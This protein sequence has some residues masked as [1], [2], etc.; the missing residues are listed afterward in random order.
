[1]TETSTGY[2]HPERPSG[3]TE[4]LAAL[5]LESA[6]LESI[7][8]T[9]PQLADLALILNGAYQPLRG[10]MNQADYE[11]VLGNLRLVDGSPF[12]LPVTLDVDLTTAR[13]METGKRIT[14]RDG[15]RAAFAVLT[16]EDVWRRDNR[17]EARLLGA[18][19][20]EQ[21]RGSCYLGG[22][23]E[24]LRQPA[25]PFFARLRPSPLA[26]S[27]HIKKRAFDRVLGVECGSVIQK[28][29]HRVIVR[30]AAE[31]D[32]AILLQPAIGIP[33]PGNAE[34]VVTIKSL[35]AVLPRFPP[36][37]TLLAL[38]EYPLRKIGLREFLMHAMLRKRYG[39]THFM[40]KGATQSV[41]EK[42]VRSLEFIDELGIEVLHW[43]EPPVATAGGL[44]SEFSADP[45]AR[46]RQEHAE[47]MRRIRSGERL[48]EDHLFPEVTA[49]L[50]AH[51]QPGKRRGFTLFFTG[52]SGSG[53][54]TIAKIVHARV[55]E[56]DPRPVTLIGGDILRKQFSK[57]LGFSKEDH[58]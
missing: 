50:E 20:E 53:K 33:D 40:M 43:D 25:H 49:L 11:A 55:A 52:L 44:P 12:P 30:A 31:L 39:A 35:L 27:Q 19:D 4:R 15:E 37:G 41:V 16:V 7:V 6:A 47:L 46:I 17:R 8:L 24:A 45:G 18:F 56:R 14:L 3:D 5:E 9:P 29:H 54:S 34:Q 36:R 2:D 42:Q 48:T 26:L 57:G 23:I 51:Y 58:D 13:S 1:M 21:G 28:Q 10:Y 32:A 22:S 38:L